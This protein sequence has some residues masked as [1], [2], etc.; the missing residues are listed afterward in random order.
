MVLVVSMLRR[1]LLLLRLPA[2]S[3]V[4]SGLLAVAAAACAAAIRRRTSWLRIMGTWLRSMQQ[5]R[6]IWKACRT[7][8]TMGSNSTYTQAKQITLKLQHS[9]GL[10][11][12]RTV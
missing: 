3:A 6:L 5:E 8:F 9:G 7:A 11:R 4:A 12:H 2:A 1:K 10:Y